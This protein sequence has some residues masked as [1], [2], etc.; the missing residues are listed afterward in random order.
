MYTCKYVL[1]LLCNFKKRDS[2]PLLPHTGTYFYTFPHSAFLGEEEWGGRGGAS[3][4]ILSKAQRLN[5]AFKS[6]PFSSVRSMNQTACLDDLQSIPGFPTTQKCTL[7]S[8][9]VLHCLLLSLW[10]NMNPAFW[11][12]PHLPPSAP[13]LTWHASDFTV[14]HLWCVSPHLTVYSWQAWTTLP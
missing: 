9:S 4:N 13:G 8:S 14:L 12:L 1:L 3:Q 7:L 6:S 11:S 10:W 5:L 2:L